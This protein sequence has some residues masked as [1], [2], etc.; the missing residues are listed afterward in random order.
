MAKTGRPPKQID[1]QQVEN[2]AKIGCTYAEIGA[3]VGCSKATLN[4]RFRTTISK[5]HENLKMSIRRMQLQAAN[6][7]NIVM[8][9]WLGKQYLG[10]Q[11]K[12]HIETK[13]E[14]KVETS[15]DI[16]TIRKELQKD[17][18]YADYIRNRMCQSDV[19]ASDLG[20]N[21]HAKLGNVKALGNGRPG[22]NG[23]GNGHANGN[24]KH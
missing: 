11:D 14:A 6:K 19:H 13:D 9:I 10:Q 20:G 18:G 3:I 24:R 12:Q 7:G 21:G 23:N 2:L 5:G 4:S 22:S 1:E 8:M 17:P 16:A 15:R